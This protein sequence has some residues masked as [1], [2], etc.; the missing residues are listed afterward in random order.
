MVRHTTFF[1]VISVLLL[2]G[3]INKVKTDI[4]DEICGEIIEET[5]LSNDTEPKKDYKGRR[6][7]DQRSL[8]IVFD[9]TGS[10]ATDLNQ[11]RTSAKVIVNKLA[12]YKENPIHNFV[13]SVF[14]DP[15]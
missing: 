3:V 7:P 13:L 4:S 12:T 5:E 2:I 8:I 1:G 15:G 6:R 10:M 11:L 9:A 14:R